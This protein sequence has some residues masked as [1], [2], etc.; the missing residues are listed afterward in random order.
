MHS[1]SLDQVVTDGQF[2]DLVGVEA[3]V[4][5]EWRSKKRLPTPLV[6]GP[7]LRAYCYRLREQAALRLGQTD[8][9]LDLVQERAAL[10]KAQR[11]NVETKTAVLRGQ[12]AE[13]ALLERVLAAAAGAVVEKFDHLPA[14]LRTACPELPQAALDQV[15]ST[16]VAA[17]NEWAKTTAALVLEVALPDEEDEPE[18]PLDEGGD[19]AA[20]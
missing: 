5:C 15:M 12:Y 1:F 9:G 19:D 13:T 20:P 18:L 17:R 10:A 11:E 16:I 14:K 8:G 4:V 6:V 3:P 2:G 7:A